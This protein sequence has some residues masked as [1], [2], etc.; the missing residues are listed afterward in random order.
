MKTKQIK[1]ELRNILSGKS[2]QS[3]DATIQAIL[4]YLGRSESSSKMAENKLEDKSEEKKKLVAFATQNDFFYRSIK[5]EKFVSQGAEQKVYIKSKEYV[6]KLNDAIYYASWKDYFYNLLLH[7]YFF[8]DT[9]YQFL[10]FYIEDNVLFAVVKQKF[11]KAT[12]LTNL[13]NV[14]RFML[15]NGFENNRNHDYYHPEIGII[16][17]DLHDENVLTINDSLFFIDTVFFF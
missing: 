5:K 8:A 17:E 9:A 6:I 14:K 16:L 12:T 7:N 13:S 2:N 1:N 11:V 10:G 3:Y 4:S 15:S